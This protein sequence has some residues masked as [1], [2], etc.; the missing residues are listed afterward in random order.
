MRGA[1]SLMRAG[2]TVI[3]QL[4][5]QV[6]HDGF[7]DRDWSVSVEVWTFTIKVVSGSQEPLVA[8]AMLLPVPIRIKGKGA[9]RGAVCV[10]ARSCGPA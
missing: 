5:G 8:A 3:P 2:M 9:S 10:C 7:W 1:R 6:A 4:Y